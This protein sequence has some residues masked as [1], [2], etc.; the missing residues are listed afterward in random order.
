MMGS[1][2]DI[3]RE[4]YAVPPGDFTAARTARAAEVKLRDPALARS[5]GTLKRAS[6]PA[7]VV[8]QLVR[9]RADDIEQA[10]ALAVQMRDA[11]DELDAAAMSELTTAR[12]RLTAALARQGASIAKEKGV[13]VSPAALDE[14]SQ[15][16]QAA[17]TDE[18]AAAALLSGRLVRALQTVGFDAVDLSGAVAGGEAEI[19]QRPKAGHDDL[20]KRRA[21]RAAEKALRDAEQAAT[22]TAREVARLD[23]QLRNARERADSLI[24]TRDGL[25]RELARVLKQLE[26]VQSEEHRLA[27][28][29]RAAAAAVEAAET[30][31]EAAQEALEAHAEPS[32]L[33]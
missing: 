27:D 4:L 12:R 2:E 33:S 32:P 10:L 3:A 11:Q 30:A 26:E 23:T 29:R 25:E 19:R 1:L 7:W 22:Q 24:E 14:V 21:R 8:G 28:E 31:K 5:I 16:L 20:A 6:V 17:M 13:P 9:H 18:A 15:T